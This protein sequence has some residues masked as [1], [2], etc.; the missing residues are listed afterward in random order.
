M[1]HSV[2]AGWLR[3]P[4]TSVI[5]LAALLST[6]SPAN[7][8][9]GVNRWTSNG[10]EGGVAQ[11]LVIDPSRPAT[12]YAGMVAGGVFKSTD[13]GGSWTVMSAGLSNTDVYAL[14]IDPSAPA[15]L[16]AG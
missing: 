16:Y 5:L 8:S 4:W 15:T 3:S 7:S 6:V 14:A 1:R 12:L 2:T 11:S 10:P 9:A 13:N